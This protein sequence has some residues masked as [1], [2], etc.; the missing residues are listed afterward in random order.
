MTAQLSI[1]LA[2]A[3]LTD[4]HELIALF[5]HLPVDML[6]FDLE[7]GVFIPGIT[8]GTKIISDLRPLTN[9]CFEAHLMVMDP[10]KYIADLA[11]NGV[12]RISVHWEA[13]PDPLRT[14]SMIKDCGVTSGIAFNPNTQIPNLDFLLPVLDYVNVLSTEPQIKDPRFIPEMLAKISLKKSEAT[15]GDLRWEIDG[16]LDAYSANLAIKHGVDIVVVGRYIFENVNISENIKA[17][18]NAISEE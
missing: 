17:I 10:E 5:N 2:A 3:P 15:L 18:I 12:N 9:I 13:C 11:A 16:G 1:S 7:D 4:L 8:L 6:H 14:L